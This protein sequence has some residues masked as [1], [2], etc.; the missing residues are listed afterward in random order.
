MKVQHPEHLRIQEDSILRKNA[1]WYALFKPIA[2]ELEDIP[3][4][5]IK[6]EPLSVMAYGEPGFRDSGDI[7]LLVP[8]EQLNRVTEILHKYHFRNLLFDE[9]GNPR[10]LTRR[11]KIMFLRSHQVAP[12]YYVYDTRLM[13]IDVNVDIYWGEYDGKRIALSEVLSDTVRM[14][15]HGTTVKTLSEMHA[16]I[17]LCLHH[18]KEMNS[19]YGFK[20]KN[21]F[22]TYMFQDIY[23]FYKRHME[24]RID[25]LL[26]YSRTYDL[27]GILYYLFHYTNRVFR[28]EALAE[29]AKRFETPRAVRD[30]RMYGLAESEK[31]AWNIDFETRL[32][33]PDLF[34]LLEPE[35][36]AA[37]I[38]KI[39]LVTGVL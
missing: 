33:H 3:Y 17:E 16:F 39:N 6:G 11:E 18:Y 32:D 34:G 38:E 36:T 31:R 23:C 20:L 12:F 19:I 10:E 37:D 29:H 2:E 14:N 24:T 5:V 35:L 8:R 1:E 13:N 30:L 9:R 27:D 15:L 22:A 7:D 4:A 28:D 26:E 25:E 21:P